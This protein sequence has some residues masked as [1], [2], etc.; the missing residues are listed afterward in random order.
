MDIIGIDI[1]T[2][3][4]KYLRLQRG[5]KRATVVS[6]G[7]FE[8][9]GTEDALAE[10]VSNIKAKEGT[11]CEI[12]IG[13]TSQEII[14]RT[15]TIPVM[16]KAEVK[17]AINWS[18]SKV[19]ST[20]IEEMI[21]DFDIIGE[22]DERGIK[23]EDVL[24]IGME[25]TDAAR[26]IRIF[27]DV[28]LKNIVLITDTSLAYAPYLREITQ[29]LVAVLDVGGRLT[30]IYLVERGKTVF[31]REVMTASESFS[32]ALISGFGLSYE[33]AERYKKEKGIS[34]EAIDILSIPLERLVGEIQRTFN[35]FNQKYPDR[36]VNRIYITGGGSYMP[37]FIDRLKESL[38]EEFIHPLV[39][40]D[41]ENIYLPSYLLSTMPHRPFNLLPPEVKTQLRYTRYRKGIKIGT[42]ALMSLLCFLTIHLWAKFKR[43]DGVLLVERANLQKKRE[44]MAELSNMASLSKFDMLL[45]VLN[46]VKRKDRTWGLFLRYLSSQLPKDVFLKEVYF[47]KTVVD[48][49]TKAKGEPQQTKT[50]QTDKAPSKEVSKDISKDVKSEQTTL[51]GQQPPTGDG[52]YFTLKGY[53]FGEQG[54]IDATFLEMIIR[55]EESGLLYNIE[56][57]G[58]EIKEIGNRA[59]MEF[60]VI[61]RCMVYEI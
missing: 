37:H 25:K 36:R 3:S 15:F 35:V 41:I 6:T 10:I 28:G 12:A 48:T 53:I 17:E 30:G 1:G 7:Y 55:F 16:P 29:D 31:V 58:K 40:E 42:V 18:A 22:V 13:L 57:K 23:K 44:Y 32:D 14:K 11:N 19:I 60:V 8:Y 51:A 21:Y 39:N 61:G 27:N 46:E 47:D 49:E 5:S 33:E 45:P 26:I 4:I 52:Y 50:A 59:V 54:K 34:G 2:I 9:R 38:G 24:F 43:I 56:T 20:P